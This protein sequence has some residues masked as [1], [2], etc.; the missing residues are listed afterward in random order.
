M[1]MLTDE[2]KNE[3][4]KQRDQKLFELDI[5]RKKSPNDLWRE[6]LD[7]FSEQLE[8]VEEKERREEAGTVKK[9]KEKKP[10]LVSNG[11]LKCTRFTILKVFVCAA[12]EGSKGR[13]RKFNNH[14]C[15]D[16][17]CMMHNF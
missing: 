7:V 8:I 11:T 3:L 15:F 14:Y 16:T 13:V 10:T 2:R 4:L 6:D 17:F 9:E 12:K 1:W 5:L